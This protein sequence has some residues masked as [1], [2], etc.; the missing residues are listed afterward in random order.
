VTYI[1][2][3][4][5][6]FSHLDRLTDWERGRRVAPVTLE[7]DLSNRC[8]LGCQDCHFAYTHTKGPWAARPRSLPM[9]KSAGG[10]LADPALVHRVLGEV[11]ALGVQGIVWSGGGEPT[12]HPE[13]TEI[14][15]HAAD[16]GLEQGMYTLGGLLTPVTGKHLAQRAT[17]VVVSLDCHTPEDYAREK[18]VPASRFASACN[19]IV[20]LVGYRAVV[21]VSFLLHQD[22][23]RDAHKMRAFAQHLGAT[24]S[25]FRPAIRFDSARPAEP[26][27]D[28]T[29]VGKAM[30]LLTEL[31]KERDVECDPSR[32]QMWADWGTTSRGYHACTGIRL[33]AAITPDGRVWVCTERRER[34]DSCLG[35]LRTE[36]FAHI[37][38]RHP[39]QWTDFTECRAM[40]RLHRV[41]QQL[42]AIAQPRPHAAFV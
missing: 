19:G 28:R 37:W 11:K 21:G 39:G 17:W 29:W 3:R 31:A 4:G 1:D 42:D 13:W 41:N 27:G 35:D 16:L 9:L 38:A 12:T 40:C 5:K 24:Y 32:F 36:S 10:D 18:G 15:A 33:S 23:W 6:V 30:P 22:N 34:K 8:V 7:W 26:L 2:P 14:I 25:T 20:S